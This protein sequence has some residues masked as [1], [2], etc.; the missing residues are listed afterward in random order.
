MNT[1]QRGLLVAILTIGVLLT[2]CSGPAGTSTSQGT[3]P[4]EERVTIIVPLDPGGGTDMIARKLASLL[5][6]RIGKQVVVENRPG[7]GTVVGLNRLHKAKPDGTTLMLIGSTIASVKAAGQSELTPGDFTPLGMVNNDPP[8][9]TVRADSKW[10]TIDDF[11]RHVRANPDKVRVATGNPQGVWDVGAET[12]R[13]RSKLPWRNVPTEGGAA[14][15]VTA[16][17]GERVE[18]VTASVPEVLEQVRAGKLKVLSVGSDERLKFL[19]EVPTFAEAKLTPEPLTAPR[20]VL[21]P[22]DMDQELAKKIE[23]DVLAVAKSKKFQR[24]LAKNAMAPQTLNAKQTRK[25]LDGQVKQYERVFRSSD[26]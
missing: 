10:D 12:L 20:P 1:R 22:P 13:E 23:G 18:A 7:G 2:A 15:S 6:A 19:P 11:V 9:I 25:Y 16:L 24:F 14:P 8:T 26:D 5:E 3:W 21:A 4:P 17:L